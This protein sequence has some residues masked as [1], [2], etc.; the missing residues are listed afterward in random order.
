MNNDAKIMSEK[1][2]EI[3]AFLITTQLKPVVIPPEVMEAEYA[4]TNQWHSEGLIEHLFAR[5]E[6][7][8]LGGGILVM[9]ATG[10][11]QAQAKMAELPLAPYFE[12][13]DYVAIDKIY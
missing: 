10:L 4:M 12:R 11:E 8:K 7:G 6:N 1:P 9:R 13:I 3:N 2:I 5:V